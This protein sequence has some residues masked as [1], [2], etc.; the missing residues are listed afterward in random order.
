MDS[1]NPERAPGLFSHNKKHAPPHH[2]K[3]DHTNQT[4]P[5]MDDRKRMEENQSWM[6]WVLHT[7]PGNLTLVLGAIVLYGV[8]VA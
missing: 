1:V 6:N 7:L 8:V 3:T 4:D 2:K 5:D